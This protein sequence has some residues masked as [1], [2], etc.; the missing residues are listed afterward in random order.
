LDRPGAAG[1]LT[2]TIV[3]AEEFAES[4][5]IRFIGMTRYRTF[6]LPA[7]LFLGLYLFVRIFPWRKK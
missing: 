5:G 3:E 2:R 7:L 6:L 1:E 4:R